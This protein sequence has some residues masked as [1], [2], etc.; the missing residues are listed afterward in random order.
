[1]YTGV[2]SATLSKAVRKVHVRLFAE[3]TA[4][5]LLKDEIGELYEA[6]NHVWTDVE[7]A[8]FGTLLEQALDKDE[9]KRL[10]AH[11][12][13]RAYV[14]RLVEATIIQPL[15]AEWEGAVLG[16]VERERESDPRAA[17]AAVH[18][19]HVKLA[20]TRVPDPQRNSVE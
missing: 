6:A 13:P 10:G 4:I 7:P 16:T 14:E 3:R 9:R 17:I 20:R 1:M 12:T 15:K 2:C 11:Y 18:D 19:F 8:I 5:T